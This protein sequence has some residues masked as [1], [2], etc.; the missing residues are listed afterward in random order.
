MEVEEHDENAMVIDDPIVPTNTR[1][2]SKRKSAG[3]VPPTV[4][5]PPKPTHAEGQRRTSAHVVIVAP[6]EPEEDDAESKRV[7][8]KR[9]TSSEA[10]EEIEV[11]PQDESEAAAERVA[12]ELEPYLH[13]SPE[14]QPDGDQWDDLDEE[15]A[16]D[17]L[18]V[19]DYVADIFEYY[20]QIEVFIFRFHHPYHD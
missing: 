9:R 20:K 19:S 1:R 8:K 10:P 11:E 2:I 16:D 17:P 12:A 5:E 7:F 3:S 13:D 18:M 15:D 6:P 14:A 4:V